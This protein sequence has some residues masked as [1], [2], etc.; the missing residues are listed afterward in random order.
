M[1]GKTYSNALV[2]DS[3]C[4]GYEIHAGNIACTLGKFCEIPLVGHRCTQYIC[5]NLPDDVMVHCH[6]ER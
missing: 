2:M 3:L 1:E 4:V 5:S 6:R